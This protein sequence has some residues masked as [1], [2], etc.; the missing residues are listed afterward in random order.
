MIRHSTGFGTFIDKNVLPYSYT[1]P[2][3]SE[4]PCYTESVDIL[5]GLVSCINTT[6]TALPT[7]PASD[8]AATLFFGRGWS[9]RRDLL[10]TL[11]QRHFSDVEGRHRSNVVGTSLN[12]RRVTSP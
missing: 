9:R 2:L 6:R 4:N 7:H 3:R 8:V 12:R 1:D 11:Q 10:A 5:T